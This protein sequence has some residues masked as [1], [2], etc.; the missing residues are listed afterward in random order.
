MYVALLSGV[1]EKKTIKL[2]AQVQHV[3]QETQA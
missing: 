2:Y 3:Q 1:K